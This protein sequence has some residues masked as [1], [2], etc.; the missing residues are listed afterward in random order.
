[1]S[2]KIGVIIST[3]RPSRIGPKVAD[4]FISK[5]KSL[6]NAVFEIID[7][8]EVN[9]PFLKDQASPA[10]QQYDQESTKKWSEIISNYDG[11]VFVTAEYNNGYPAPLKNA[12]DTVYHEWDKKPVAFV[13][14]GTFGAARAIEQL[15][16]V[17]AKIGMVP[18]SKTVVGIISPWQA[19]KEDG[20]V[21]EAFVHG[22]VD[23]LLD[24]LMWWSELTKSKRG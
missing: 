10:E 11:F 16:N 20:S 2:V 8:K 23:G 3:T 22:K 4:W 15:V 18:L 14:Y 21:D 1:M 9:L 12:L 6:N 17:T 19:I 5:T 24:N 7:L 13:G